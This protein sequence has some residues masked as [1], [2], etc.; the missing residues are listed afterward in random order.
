M[1]N[2]R[3]DF[4]TREEM[5]AYLAET[6]PKPYARSP[7][8]TPT[9]G[10]RTAAEAQMK[11]APSY[12]KQYE[13]TRNNL[14][15]AVSRLSPYLRHGVLSLAEVRDYALA[16]VENR[17]DVEKFINELAVRDY[18][19]RLYELKGDAVIWQDVEPYKTGFVAKDYADE[20]PQDI[21]DAKTGVRFIDD[22]VHE[23]Y[24][25][26]YL[27]NH[28]RMWLAGYVVHWRRIKWQVGARWFLEH[29]LDGD[30]ASNNLSWQWVASTFS[31]K[32][33]Y[34]NLDNVLKY[35]GARYQGDPS[36]FGH[37]DFVGTYEDLALR[38][39]PNVNLGDEPREKTAN[40]K[41]GKR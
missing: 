36:A 35:S 15:G 4:A 41:K 8:I 40:P 10:G 18:W 11:R 20:L 25:T 28:A 7:Q 12:G 14:D 33:Y 39:F 3:K 6:F 24:N 19:Q 17:D 34:Y 13:R 1:A 37:D 16:Q 9:K 38:L 2:L 32:P 29:L 5:L 21:R 30:P 27:H 26:G 31:H 23:L 22:C